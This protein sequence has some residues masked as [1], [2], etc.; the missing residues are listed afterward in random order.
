M[1]LEHIETLRAYITSVGSTISKL[2]VPP[3]AS[4][5]A[6]QLPTKEAM[7]VWLNGEEERAFQALTTLINQLAR[8]LAAA[9]GE[10]LSDRHRS[11]VHLDP[12]RDSAII[13]AA[14]DA[15]FRAAVCGHH[16]PP[17]RILPTICLLWK[18]LNGEH[19]TCVAADC[20]YRRMGHHCP[21]NYIEVMSERYA[22][23][24]AAPGEESEEQDGAQLS[25]ANSFHTTDSFHTAGSSMAD[26]HDDADSHSRDADGDTV[27]QRA[28]GQ[29][30]GTR[31]H[32]AATAAA[33]ARTAAAAA[34]APAAPRAAPAERER[35]TVHC[36]D[37]VFTHHKNERSLKGQVRVRLPK[38]LA[39][40]LT[41]LNDFVCPAL[42]TTEKRLFLSPTGLALNACNVGTRFKQQQRDAGVEWEPITLQQCR[43]VHAEH[44]VK[45]LH[46]L[47]AYGALDGDAVVMNNSVRELQRSYL[48]QYM[49]A[50]SDAAV[51]RVQAWRRLVAHL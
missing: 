42:S 7:Y 12:K 5:Q 33:A 30:I 6:H 16:V 17:M 49:C 11:M 14:Q 25:N 27:M 31:L 32:A 45:G 51:E 10:Q 39:V 26:T 37:V 48:K 43:H 18:E 28:S 46:E 29:G 47:D 50:A 8:R 41:L 23:P 4:S 34:A 24:A 1:Q 13:S 21:G 36:L 3:L 35:G 19:P 15:G 20:Q 2:P 22:P 44:C 38:S 40:I 9:A